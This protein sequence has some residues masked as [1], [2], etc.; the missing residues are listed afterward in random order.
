MTPRALLAALIVAE[1]ARL[2]ALRKALDDSGTDDGSQLLTL[3]AAADYLSYHPAT[4][5]AAIRS[6][7]LKAER[8]GLRGKYRVRRS[9]L[10][11]YMDRVRRGRGL[12]EAV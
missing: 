4:I 11:A 1:Q 12:R 6:G 5:R 2:D 3:R 10:D 8:A 7:S 9:E